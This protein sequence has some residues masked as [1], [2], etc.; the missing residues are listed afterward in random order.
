MRF[1]AERQAINAVI[2]GFAANITKMAM[3]D[4]HDQARH[5]PTHGCSSRST[6]RSSSGSMKS[7][8]DE[9]LTLVIDA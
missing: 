7:Y 1:R 2:Q 5:L 8:A 9:V 6:T 3:L 4:L